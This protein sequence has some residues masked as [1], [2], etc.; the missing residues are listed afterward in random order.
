[1]LVLFIIFIIRYRKNKSKNSNIK[2]IKPL[3]SAPV[4]GK[5]RYLSGGENFDDSQ[6]GDIFSLENTEDMDC[7]KSRSSFME[8]DLNSLTMVRREF[9]Q[10][11]ASNNRSKIIP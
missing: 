1:L 11:I 6:T 8:D 2:Q 4:N 3:W 10:N 5:Y 7:R 9:D